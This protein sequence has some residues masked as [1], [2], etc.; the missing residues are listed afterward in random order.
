[1]SKKRHR[2]REASDQRG[3]NNQMNS[4]RIN[5]GSNNPFGINPAQLLNLFGGTDMSQ[6]GNMLSSMGREGFD[7]SNFGALGNMNNNQWMNGMPNVGNMQGQSTKTTA[8]PINSNH[9]DAENLS[10]KTK[11][12]HNSINIKINNSI[13]DENIE[14]LR[15]I[16]IIAEPSKAE[17]IDKI[18]EKYSEGL[19]DD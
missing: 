10:D 15:A 14:F 13:D 2:N 6:I 18:I 1:M 12:K 7:L 11:N 5:N 16:R 4:N 8:E 19:F 3:N 17:F 9:M